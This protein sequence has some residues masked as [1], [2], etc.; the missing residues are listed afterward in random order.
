VI[1]PTEETAMKSNDATCPDN[2]TNSN[3]QDDDFDTKYVRMMRTSRKRN[4]ESPLHTDSRMREVQFDPNRVEIEAEM[5]K[6]EP[7]NLTPVTTAKLV[8]QA[9]KLDRSAA[10][11]ASEFAAEYSLKAEEKRQCIRQVMIARMAQ[12]SLCGRIRKKWKWTED[13]GKRDFLRWL[14]HELSDIEGHSSESDEPS[15]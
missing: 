3:T 6:L 5:T 8:G 1:E 15:R 11:I 9:V 13:T 2:S 14:D 12:R 7:K 10:D 4:S